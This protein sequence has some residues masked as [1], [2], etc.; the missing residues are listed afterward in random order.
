[1]NKEEKFV[2]P[3]EKMEIKDCIENAYEI[4]KKNGA[5]ERPLNFGESL[6]LIVSELSE[7]LEADRDEK[8][9][10]NDRENYEWLITESELKADFKNWYEC[11]IKGTVEDELADVAIRL[12]ALAGR[13]R[14]DLEYFIK[15][16]MEYN[17]TRPYKHGRSYL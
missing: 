15:T 13:Y 17:K 9:L 5:Y 2:L 10:G 7:A 8:W 14:V 16:K 3:A 1:M 4:A 12:F 11:N 6:M